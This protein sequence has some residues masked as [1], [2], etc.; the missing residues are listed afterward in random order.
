LPLKVVKSTPDVLARSIEDYLVACRSRGVKPSTIRNAYGWPLRAVF[1]PWCREQ[2]VET[3][4][5]LDRRTIER[6]A[7]GLRERTTKAG[8]PFSPSTVWTYVKAVNQYAAWLAGENGQDKAIKIKLRKPPGRKVDVLERDQVRTLE[9]AAQTERDK[10]IIR[11]LADSGLRPGELVSLHGADIRR[12]GRRHYVRVRGKSG[13][14]DVP[15]TPDMYARLR[16]LSRGDD[17]PLFVGLRRDRRTGEREALTVN[18]VRQAIA[19]LALDSGLRKAVVT[20]YT[21]RH[22]ACRW[23]L[24]SGLSTVEVAAILG[25]GSERMIAEH[26]ANIGRE[27]AHDRLMALLRAES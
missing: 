13:E 10:V 22:S 16:G 27:D 24:M 18:G 5:Q 17:E 23:M 25:H 12:S 14:R 7:A 9:R 26:Y 15:V 20:P 1:L 19:D 8:K 21:F 3:P 11:L 2:G 4:V 6:Y